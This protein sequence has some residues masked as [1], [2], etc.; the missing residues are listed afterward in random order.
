MTGQHVP[1]EDWPVGQLAEIDW[2]SRLDGTVETYVVRRALP[3]KGAAIYRNHWET[4]DEKWL[5][6]D[7][8]HVTAVRPLRLVPQDAEPRS[9]RSVRAGPARIS[10][11]SSRLEQVVEAALDGVSW[12]LIGW[13]G[14][15]GAM[16]NPR[17]A[18]AAV[19]RAVFDAV[20]EDLA[21]E[22]ARLRDLVTS[23]DPKSYAQDPGFSVAISRV[24]AVLDEPSGGVVVGAARIRAE[25][26]AEERD[27][28]M[29]TIL[30]EFVCCTPTT[31][32]DMHTRHEMC[33]VGY[34]CMMIARDEWA[35]GSVPVATPQLTRFVLVD[36][37]ESGAGR[38]LDVSGVQVRLD[39]QDDGRTLKVFLTDGPESVAAPSVGIGTPAEEVSGGS[40][41]AG[42]QDQAGWDGLPDDFDLGAAGPVKPFNLLGC[43]DEIDRLYGQL[44][45]GSTQLAAAWL[46]VGSLTA[47]VARLEQE[48]D[49]ARRSCD[50]AWAERNSARIAASGPSHW[51]AVAELLRETARVHADA[52]EC[53]GGDRFTGFYEADSEIGLA[54]CPTVAALLP[55]A[56]QIIRDL[57]DGQ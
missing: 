33:Q 54:L 20:S 11:Q 31:D 44:Q 50:R 37:R 42:R 22:R 14:E 15:Q 18:A 24:L 19:G 28:I 6:Q 17:D 5:L 36:H 35:A 27:R 16:A 53:P 32:P 46:D 40:D 25:A 43:H 57:G 45:A 12:D 48:R 34:A 9:D 8:P 13:D 3:N 55:L 41:E 51:G 21:A 30:T 49:E 1:V 10:D 23:L 4:L 2:R 39:Y 29:Q 7:G 38:V 52:H 56:D 47:R 26:V